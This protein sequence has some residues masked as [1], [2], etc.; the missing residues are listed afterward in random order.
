MRHTKIRRL[1]FDHALN[2][3]PQQER[4]T[5]E[6][7]L[8]TC[9][10]CAADLQRLTEALGLLKIPLTLPSDELPAEYW[11]RFAST[12][13]QKIDRSR[14][15]VPALSFLESMGSF[16]LL[17]PARTAA[18]MGA[19]VLATIAFLLFPRQIP[20]RDT[21]SSEEPK[22]QGLTLE[23]KD[24][25]MSDYLRRSKVLLVGLAN[26]KTDDEGP[27]DLSAERAASRKLVLEARYLKQQPLDSR[28]SK[29]IND[30]DKIMIEVANM[31]DN[32]DKPD[33]DFIRGGIH[34]ENLLFKIRM[35][36]NY[37]RTAGYSGE[38][39]ITEDNNRH[40][41]K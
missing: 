18:T 8:R 23:A 3:L 7:H 9:S 39:D 12:V 17:R 19:L 11:A 1:L 16:L 10:S 22:V 31:R 33:V 40:Q 6:E 26:M 32:V 29:L 30:M 37:Y 25:R 13:D 35:A 4:A 36:E 38:R 14:K 28:S 15:E 20:E 5:I 41:L 34:Q 24:A 27:V 21:A 2:E